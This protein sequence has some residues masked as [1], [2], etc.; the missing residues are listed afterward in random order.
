MFR[1]E[2]PQAGRYRE[3]HQIECDILSAEND[4][5]YDAQVILVFARIFRTLRIKDVTIA[6]NSIGCRDCR[7]DIVKN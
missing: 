2:Q 4:P 3:F 7:L 6:I 1:Y 5:V